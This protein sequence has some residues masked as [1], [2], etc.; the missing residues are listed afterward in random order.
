MS[1]DLWQLYLEKLAT[2][3]TALGDATAGGGGH[4]PFGV[5]AVPVPLWDLQPKVVEHITL[6]GTTAV[7]L[8]YSPVSDVV[9]LPETLAGTPTTP[10]VEGAGN[11]Y[12]LDAAQGTIARDAAGV[13]GNGDT[14]KVTY[15]ANPQMLL[16]HMNNFVVGIGRD[17]RIEKDRDI[18]KGVNQYAITVKVAVTFEENSAI[19]KVKN[20]GTGV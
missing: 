9:V 18:F 11:D 6:T 16:T 13:I 12:V 7:A 19:V 15:N 8:K 5:Q 1:P 10:F 4:A 20:I 17:I 2:R 14:V 3:A